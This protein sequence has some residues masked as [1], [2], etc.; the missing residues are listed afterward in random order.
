MIARADAIVVLGCRLRPDGRAGRA[1]ERRVAAGVALHAAGAAPLVVLSGGGAGPRP[2]AEVMRELA[3]SLGAPAA[4]LLLET[5]SRDTIENALCSAALL[6]AR[7]LERAILVTDRYHALRAG[8]LFRRAG[9]EVVRVATPP[10]RLARDWPM[11]LRE[12]LALPRSLVR[13][14]LGRRFRG[15]PRR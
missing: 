6:R 10:A 8:L 1:L 12:A 3:L 7:G 11:W 14:A 9:V 13:L 5:A 2:E 15:L 4:S